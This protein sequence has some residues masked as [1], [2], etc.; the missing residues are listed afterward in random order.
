M[1]PTLFNL[2]LLP[3]GLGLLGFVEPCSLGAT[4]VFIKFLEGKPG[5]AKVLQVSLYALTRALLIGALGLLA[6]L[7]GTLLLGGIKAVWI[8]LGSAYVV[9]GLLY[10]TGR[11]GFLMRS[12]G[13]RL[14]RLAGWRGSLALGVL[15]G[16]NIPACATPL[17]FVLLGLAATGS[18]AGDALAAGF[19]SLA[20][21]GLALSAPLVLAVLWPPAR[22]GLDRLAALSARVPVWTGVVLILLGLWSVGFGL[23]VDFEKWSLGR[24]LPATSL[25]W[26]PQSSSI[27]KLS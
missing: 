14:G 19:V 23:L 20:L 2:V 21:F 10:V 25:H 22:R 26:H 27:E 4:L 3:V 1:E 15:F 8:G 11:A 13:P 6:A 24:G 17:I 18:A 16:L 7:A 12:L 9:L 5:A